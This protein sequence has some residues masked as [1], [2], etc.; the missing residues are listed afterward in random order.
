MTDKIK[1][2][3][4]NI[5]GALLTLALVCLLATSCI[6][7]SRSVEFSLTT[8]SDM[9][10]LNLYVSRLGPYANPHGGNS[11]T[12]EFVFPRGLNRISANQIRQYF[13]NYKEERPDFAE[14]GEIDLK[15]DGAGCVI[16]VS[17]KSADGQ[18]FP[19]NGI[20]QMTRCGLT[21]V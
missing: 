5:F 13:I 19:A 6:N 8:S 3:L 1:R 9:T 14:S 7:Y 20:H 2:L 12:Y 4:P 11:D 15:I 10:T 18:P 21:Q 16:R 17:L